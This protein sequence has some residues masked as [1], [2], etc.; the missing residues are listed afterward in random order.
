MF[1]KFV[2][3]TGSLVLASLVVVS[4]AAAQSAPS[5]ENGNSPNSYI[6]LGGAIGLNGNT[7]SLGTGGIPILS[8]VR[9]T[10][11]FSLHDATVL[12]GGG[13]ATSM[14][15]LTA[16]LPIRNAEGRTIAAPFIGAGA[17]LRY[18]NGLYVSP[19]ISG[20][21]DIPLSQRFTGTVRVN[22][23]FPS[24]RQADVGVLVGVGYSFGD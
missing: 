2:G 13:A 11:N 23:G 1:Q 17:L 19:A 5:I 21:V 18:A 16:D 10:D 7:T 4:P 3:L 22:A 20:G 15:I 24:D 14:V 8:K 12:F 6:G 9:F